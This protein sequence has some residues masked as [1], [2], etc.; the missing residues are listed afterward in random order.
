MPNVNPSPAASTGPKPLLDGLAK[1]L[2]APV[3]GSTALRSD[4][5]KIAVRAMPA[6][7]SVLLIL[8]ACFTSRGGSVDEIRFC[9][10][11]AAPS[12]RLAAWGAFG[13][14]IAVSLWNL[15]TW[16]GNLAISLQPQVHE[17]EIAR[18]AGRAIVGPD[19]TVATRIGPWFASG[20]RY[21]HN[22]AFDLQTSPAETFSH[23]ELR[24]Y[25]A[26]FDAEVEDPHMSDATNNKQREAILSW[27]LDGI[28]HLRG[29]FFGERN[30]DLNDL[31]F[32]AKTPATVGGFG[33]KDGKMFRF[34]QAA[35]G[36]HELIL[37]VCPEADA[38][39]QFLGAP[40]T[41]LLNLPKSVETDPQQTLVA[42]LAK[43]GYSATSTLRNVKVLERVRGNLT[44]VDW[45]KMVDELRANDPAMTFYQSIYQIPGVS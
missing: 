33:L 32:Q 15:H 25:F 36:D 11:S 26:H 31:F 23:D 28:L 17:A 34:A 41:A 29:F 7:V 4:F 6:A 18:A 39:P 14:A 16:R 42:F 43:T 20:G 2:S 8:A 45:R 22:P 10:P 21:W 24:A 38:N 3:R 13:L 5:E 19:A 30:P 9:N 35:N 1:H 40:F 37:M 44:P 27:Y 12:L